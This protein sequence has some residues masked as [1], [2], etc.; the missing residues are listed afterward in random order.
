LEGIEEG[1]NAHAALAR[2][3]I[4]SD[5]ELGAKLSK[6]MAKSQTI[7]TPGPAGIQLRGPG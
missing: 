5:P 4:E 2:L 3:S 1:L 6:A 7:R